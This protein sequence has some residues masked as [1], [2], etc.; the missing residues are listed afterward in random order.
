M[1]ANGLISQALGLQASYFVLNGKSKDVL[2]I[3]L[4][5]KVLVHTGLRQSSIILLSFAIEIALKGLLKYTTSNFPKTHNLKILF[6]RLNENDR[7]QLSE[8][9]KRKTD[10]DI[11]G[12]LNRHKDTFNAFRYLDMETD[13]PINSEELDTALN[14]IIEYYNQIKSAT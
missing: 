11:E 3:E 2:S 13:E 12:Y 1:T 5:R 14:S 9:H 10:S 4:E 7:I 6:E 8:I